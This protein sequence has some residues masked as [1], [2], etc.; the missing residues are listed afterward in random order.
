MKITGALA[1]LALVNNLSAVECAFLQDDD[2]FTDDGDV[3]TTL[4]SMKA[5]EK[6]HSAKF[7]GLN[8]E[9]QKD[10]LN[11]KSIMTFKDDEFV[12]NDVRKFDKSFLQLDEDDR[13]YPEPR[14]IGEF[15]AQLGD[16]DE[17]ANTNMLSRTADQD[18]A[19]LGGSA[20]NDDED[21]STTLESMKTAEKMTG[22][23]LKDVESNKQ[24]ALNTGHFVH[25]FLSDDHRVYT[26]ELDNALVDKETVEAKAKAAE[27]AKKK[28]Q[29]LMQQ[30]QHQSQRREQAAQAEMAIHF[31][32]DEYVQTHESDSDSDSDDE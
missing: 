16:F 7:Q 15:M 26:N 30:E 21:I 8:Q 5:A 24:N 3:S 13:V 9:G 14:P 2:L 18:R 31:M 20:L 27:L 23:K 11:E 17:I 25:D 12:K 4:N 32:E 6:I 19:V 10:L 22:A 29:S 28:K 1:A